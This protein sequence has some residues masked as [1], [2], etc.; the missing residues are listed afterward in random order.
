MSGY[1]EGRTLQLRFRERRIG[2]PDLEPALVRHRWQS[3]RPFCRHDYCFRKRGP[4]GQSG[5]RMHFI[6][7]CVV[8]VLVATTAQAQQP[9]TLTLAL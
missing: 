6:K 2:G 5:G 4:Q 7:L 9:A 1:P 8:G 3:G